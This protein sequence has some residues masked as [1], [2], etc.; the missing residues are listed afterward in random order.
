MGYSGT[1]IPGLSLPFS[2]RMERTSDGVFLP[3][4]HGL[5]DFFISAW[6]VIIQSIQSIK[7]YPVIYVVVYVVANSVRGLLHRKISEEHLKHDNKN[8]KKKGNNTT[9]IAGRP[10]SSEVPLNPLTRWDV[11]VRSRQT[12][13][14]SLKN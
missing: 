8:D 14:F 10:G 13:F 1:S 7:P 4:D 9:H 11:R 12:G 3:C 2:F 5:D 6:Y